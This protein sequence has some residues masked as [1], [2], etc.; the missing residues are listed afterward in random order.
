MPK[1]LIT[2][3][4]SARNKGDAGIV[5]GMVQDL[6]SRD[7]FRDA[8]FTISS[9]AGPGEADG[10]PGTVIDSFVSLKRSLS[11]NS[12]VQGLGF[13]LFIY[14][15]TLLWIAGRRFLGLDLPVWSPLR[16]LLQ[17]YHKANLVIAAGGGYLYT[18]SRL[19]GNVVLLSVI[20]GFH[21][22]ALLGKPVYL[23]SQSIGPFAGRSQEWLVQRSLRGVRIVFAREDGTRRRLERWSGRRKMPAVHT[24][25]DAAFLLTAAEPPEG[26]PPPPPGGIRVGLTIRTWFRTPGDQQH[27]EQ[28]LGRFAGWLVQEMDAAVFF[29]PQVTYTSGGDDDREAAR[30]AV[31]QAGGAP[32]IHLM[33]EELDPARI[34]GLCGA[35]D[36]FVGT[37][38]HSC[39]YALSMKVP[40]L[41]VGYQPKTAG[42]MTQLGLERFVLPIEGLGLGQ[43]QEGFNRLLEERDIIIA[44]LESGIPK[45]RESA[46]QASRFIEEDFHTASVQG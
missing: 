11:A 2:N 33:E 13:L 20:Y 31:A 5:A 19:K 7:A 9:A 44:A 6:R 12:A 15:L 22:A 36:L 29:I 1:I 42:I 18:R 10:F 21:C 34:R 3:A 37:R 25:A 32:R 39:I 27:Y 14:P 41:A 17:N 24:A 4:Y 16:R 23:F 26:L 40:A 43:L 28:T 8:E 30:R 38:M 35:M 46:R 45:L